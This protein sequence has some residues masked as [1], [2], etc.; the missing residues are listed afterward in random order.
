MFAATKIAYSDILEE[1]RIFSEIMKL[2]PSFSDLLAPCNGH[3][4]ALLNLIRMV[5]LQLQLLY[6]IISNY[7][8]SAPTFGQWCQERRRCQNK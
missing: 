5:S 8:L 7:F 1:E 4:R 6:H 3:R 2:V